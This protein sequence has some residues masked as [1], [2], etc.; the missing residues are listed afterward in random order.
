MC[1]SH[2][3]EK[4]HSQNQTK[5]VYTVQKRKEE[6]AKEESSK[7]AR[8]KY[9]IKV[10]APIT[11]QQKSKLSSIYTLSVRAGEEEENTKVKL[12]NSKRKSHTTSTTLY[13][14]TKKNTIARTRT[15]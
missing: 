1:H 2:C 12:A 15:N 14:T 11:A 7:K 8:A 9:S 13:I 6:E 5:C 4:I 3:E 10:V